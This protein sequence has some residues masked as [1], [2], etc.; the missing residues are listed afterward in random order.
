MS[1]FDQT[2]LEFTGN[3]PSIN[4]EELTKRIATVAKGL[5]TNVGNVI[6]G[7]G[8][9]MNDATQKNPEEAMLIDKLKNP[10]SKFTSDDLSKL[11]KIFL[12]RGIEFNQKPEGT[13]E[14]EKEENETVGLEP[15][16]ETQTTG[17]STSY[18]GQLQGI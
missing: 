10:E 2:I 14:Q 8:G 4:P 3:L 17:S 5:P 7:V 9:A 6:S 13:P 12:D 18:G 16:K 1:K 11:Q 15:K